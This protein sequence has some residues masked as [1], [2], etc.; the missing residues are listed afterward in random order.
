[1]IEN[2]L[3]DFDTLILL[4]VKLLLEYV[5]SLL[6]RRD[7]LTQSCFIEKARSSEERIIHEVLCLKGDKVNYLSLLMV[8]NSHRMQGELIRSCRKK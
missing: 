1:M 3:L 5:I 8:H 6:E 2:I 7:L 4:E